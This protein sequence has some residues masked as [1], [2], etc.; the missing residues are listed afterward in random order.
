MSQE[1]RVPFGTN[2]NSHEPIFSELDG[3]YL[4]QLNSSVNDQLQTERPISPDIARLFGIGNRLTAARL[5]RLDN[6][7][8]TPVERQ[9]IFVGAVIKV[10]F[11]DSSSRRPKPLTNVAL[12]TC[13][14][15]I[16]ATIFGDFGPDERREFFYDGS[17]GDRHSWF[18]YQ[19]ITDSSGSV[20]TVTLHYE[21]HPTGVLR[22]SS[23]PDTKNEFIFGQELD[24]FLNATKIY[25][26]LVMSRLYPDIN[27][28]DNVHRLRDDSI[29]DRLA[30]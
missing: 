16:G 5:H 19:E 27:H 18:F 24:N 20:H 14:S 7:P 2:P 12:R 10:V 25:H 4:R 9:R 29:E 21:V 28:A 22:L 3:I 6:P 15:E 30:A 11:G 26:D 13:E 17:N 8:P 23:S 1:S